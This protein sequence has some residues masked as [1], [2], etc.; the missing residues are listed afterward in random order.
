MPRYIRNTVLLA[1]TEGTYGTDPVPTGAA[2]AILASNVS[3]DVAYN[4]VDRDLIRGYFGGSVQ[5][6]GTRSVNVSF[7]VELAGS[8]DAGLTAPAW[9]PLIRACGF[10]ES[11]A[12]AYFEY[13]PIS[14]ALPS[15]TLYYHLDGALHKVTGAR[16]TVSFDL[17]VGQRPLMKFKFTGLDGGLTAVADATPTLT[18]WKTPVVVTN[19]NS[20]DIKLGCTYATGALS[21]G[22][23]YTSTGLTLDLNADV[24]FTPLLGEEAVS[25]TNRAVS[26]AATLDLTAA[27]Q[28]SFKTAVDANTTTSLGFVHGTVAGNIITLYAP[29]VQ[30]INP[31]ITDLD[32]RVMCS[33]DLRL[34]PSAGNDEL[35]I[36]VA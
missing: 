9:G 31:K 19:T 11:D 1:K 34:M 5:L 24:K 6:V 35:K 36:A 12:G 32:G 18:A 17:T 10:A 7:D 15:V 33:Y 28:V 14:T 26:G 23:A 3:I 20:G 25:L 13:A 8:G 22:S 29:V 4:N 2:N 30:R 16:G 27:D 21:G